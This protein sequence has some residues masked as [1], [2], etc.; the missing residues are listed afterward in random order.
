MEQ[1]IRERNE[2]E[3]M[4]YDY[5]LNPIIPD[6]F[7]EPVYV[8]LTDLSNLIPMECQENCIIC[9]LDKNTFMSTKCCQH[10][11]CVECINNWFKVSVR[12]PFCNRDLRYL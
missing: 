11:F 3:W 1:L 6:D 10:K 12:C 9:Y 7:W 4:L 8:G 5:L 2:F